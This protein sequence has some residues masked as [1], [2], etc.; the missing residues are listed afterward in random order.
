MV[1]LT[2]AATASVLF[3]AVLTVSLAAWTPSPQIQDQEV[4]VLVVGAGIS[5]LAAALE[6]GRQGARVHV[7]DMWSIFGGHAVLAGGVL[8][9][10]G[11]PLQEA[12]GIEDST[13]L[14]YSDFMSWGEDPDP[15]WVRFY[16]DHS[17]ELPLNMRQSEADWN[18]TIS[19]MVTYG[20]QLTP[21]QQEILVKYAA[22]NF[23]QR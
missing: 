1:R 3:I 20:A 7:I 15:E 9:I 22:K 8:N 14:A 12:L 11:T 18:A 4:D 13:E 2:V 19:Q 6:A 16:V 17:R 10:V 5:G 21:Q 23:G